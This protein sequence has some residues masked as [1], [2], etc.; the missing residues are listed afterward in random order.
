MVSFLQTSV[1]VLLIES[2]EA[3]IAWKPLQNPSSADEDHA[4]KSKANLKIKM[5]SIFY[6]IVINKEIY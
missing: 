4:A 1:K 6:R 3:C 2:F 5:S